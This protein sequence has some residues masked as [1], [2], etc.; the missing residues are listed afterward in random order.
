LYVIY[1]K[2]LPNKK[3][4][5]IKSQSEDLKAKA[6]A[7]TRAE[8]PKRLETRTEKFTVAANKLYK[9]SVQ[10]AQECQAGDS[11]SI[12]EAVHKLHDAYKHLEKIFE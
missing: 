9:A 11:A 3:Y 5:G 6:E 2:Y 1:H 4:D 7:I 10:L 12:E 8:L